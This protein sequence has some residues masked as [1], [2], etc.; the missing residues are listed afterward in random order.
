MGSFSVM[1]RKDCGSSGVHRTGSSGV[2][3][4]KDCGSFGVRY[5]C[6]FLWRCVGDSPSGSSSE[7]GSSSVIVRE[8]YGSLGV[9]SWFVPG[10]I[11]C[12]VPLAFTRLHINNIKKKGLQHESESRIRILSGGVCD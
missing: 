10:I 3:V 1:I 2:A 6:G 4:R 7:A 12:V 5:M 8:D 9:C 11:R